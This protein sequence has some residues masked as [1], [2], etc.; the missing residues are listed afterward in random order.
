MDDDEAGSRSGTAGN[1]TEE[2]REFRGEKYQLPTV[3]PDINEVKFTVVCILQDREVIK[4]KITRENV[5]SVTEEGSTALLRTADK[6]TK[7]GGVFYKPVGPKRQIL[8]E[9]RGGRERE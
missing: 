4:L 8:F 3:R 6:I 9:N 2:N 1:K 5:Y 7:L